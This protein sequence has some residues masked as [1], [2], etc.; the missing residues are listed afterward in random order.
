MKPLLFALFILLLPAALASPTVSEEVALDHGR[1]Y[2]D[3][4]HDWNEGS[5]LV[6]HGN[7][8]IFTYAEFGL[9]G[10]IEGIR[11]GVGGEEID[12]RPT[13]LQD[14]WS[15]RAAGDHDISQFDG[16]GFKIVSVVG[17]GHHNA[18]YALRFENIDAETLKSTMGVSHI[19]EGTVSGGLMILTNRCHGNLRPIHSHRIHP[20][21]LSDHPCHGRTQQ[22]ARFG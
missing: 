13:L 5:S 17:F 20:R 22:R 6:V 18:E 8:V 7:Q 16:R 10:G 2:H 14:L 9:L 11:R 3:R 21:L 1:R 12:L 4:I 15:H 19:V